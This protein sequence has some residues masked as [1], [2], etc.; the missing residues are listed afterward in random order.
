MDIIEQYVIDYIYKLRIDRKLTQED[1][2]TIL[3]VSTS[4]IGNVETKKNPAKYNLKHIRIFAEY[5]ELSPQVF[6]PL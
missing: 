4:F 6:L 1:L 5:F 2:A 3:G